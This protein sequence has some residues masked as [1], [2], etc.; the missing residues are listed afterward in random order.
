MKRFIPF[1]L[2]AAAVVSLSSC[3]M[4][5][6][7]VPG[8]ELSST[9]LFSESSSVHDSLTGSDIAFTLGFAAD[10]KSS[11]ADLLDQVVIIRSVEEMDRHY[12][13]D[14]DTGKNAYFEH[15]RKYDEAFFAANA[16]ILVTRRETS[17]SVAH[18]TER[19]TRSGDTLTVHLR[20][21]D[22]LPRNQIMAR[23]V[24]GLEVFKGDLTGV[25]TAETVFSDN[26]IGSS[27]PH[28]STILPHSDPTVSSTIPLR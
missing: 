14:L 25:V 6:A 26:L 27:V 2:A 19:V 24:I 23:H 28:D 16:L 20:R 12:D 4:T 5:P 9:H 17:S 18:E 13:N 8:T 11:S 15:L 7:R 21:N 10:T 22:P 3:G 1:L